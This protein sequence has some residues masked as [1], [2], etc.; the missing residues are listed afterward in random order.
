MKHRLRETRAF[1][2]I[3]NEEA[4]GSTVLYSPY[5]SGTVQDYYIILHCTLYTNFSREKKT[6]LVLFVE[7]GALTNI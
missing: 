5:R 6:P 7:S 3:P 4:D 1:D 2:L